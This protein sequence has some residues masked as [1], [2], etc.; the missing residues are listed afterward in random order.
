MTRWSEVIKAN[1]EKILKLARRMYRKHYNDPVDIYLYPDGKVKDF[2]NVGGNSYLCGAGKRVCR[3]DWSRMDWEDV[4]DNLRM[5]YDSEVNFER[6][7]DEI[8]KE[9]C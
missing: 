5:H 2:Y 8:A 1:E 4:V 7:N 3:V 6:L 9:Y